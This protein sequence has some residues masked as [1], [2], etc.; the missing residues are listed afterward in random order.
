M[1][2][3]GAVA[4]I[5]GAFY[6]LDSVSSFGKEMTNGAGFIALVSRS[7]STAWSGLSAAT[8]DALAHTTTR[9]MLAWVHG[10]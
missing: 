10:A 5:G 2:V 7:T 6:T 3:A 9:V 4:G 8:T 1:S